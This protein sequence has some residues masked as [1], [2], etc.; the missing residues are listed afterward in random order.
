MAKRKAE[1]A[2][3]KSPRQKKLRLVDNSPIGLTD[4]EQQQLRD[5]YRPM[6]ELSGLGLNLEDRAAHKQ[7]TLDRLLYIY[8]EALCCDARAENT[9]QRRGRTTSLRRKIVTDIGKLAGREF[10]PEDIIKA[11]AKHAPVPK[12]AAS[13][14]RR[15]YLRCTV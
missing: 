6:S 4:A 3:P 7:L 2:K 13:A 12:F 8:V 10:T 1:P 14:I 15:D 11:L 5:L 9:N